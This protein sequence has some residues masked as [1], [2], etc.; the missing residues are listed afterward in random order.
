MFRS[1]R[2]NNKINHL[3]GSSLRI[4]HKDNYS[5]YVELLVKDKSFTIHQWNS[6][7]LAI[8]LIKVKRNLSNVIMCNIVKTRTL[9]YNLQ[10]QADFVTDSINTRRYGLNSV[11]YFAPKVWDIILSE[12]KNI[13]SFKK[14]KTE[15]RKWDLGNFLLSLSAINTELGICW[16]GLNFWFIYV[17][18][19]FWFVNFNEIHIWKKYIRIGELG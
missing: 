14:I 19:I 12:I 2:V 17:F 15:I 11:S 6:Q 9:T 18:Q 3:H 7:Y 5:S 10:S 16:F 8:E 13:N 1:R 4:A